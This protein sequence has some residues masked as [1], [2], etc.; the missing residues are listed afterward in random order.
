MSP[1]DFL[2]LLGLSAGPSHGYGLIREIE[3]LSGGATSMDPANLYRAV[4]RLKRDG[5]VEDLGRR[6]AESDDDERRRYYGLTEAGRQAA[7]AESLRLERLT[8]V[9]RE[10]RL[11][12]S[13]EGSK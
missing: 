12:P 8:A 4:K 9:A 11:V 6:P 13:T 3:T 5:L 2:I 10:R 1:R 7:R